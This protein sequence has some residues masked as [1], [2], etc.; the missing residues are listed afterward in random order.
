LRGCSSQ[1]VRPRVSWACQPPSL[2][3]A[4]KPKPVSQH[5]RTPGSREPAPGSLANSRQP[6]AGAGPGRAARPGRA[7]RRREGERERD[8]LRRLRRGGDRLR[9]YREELS[10]ERA[11][12]G[13][14]SAS[15]PGHMPPRPGRLSYQA[16]LY[17]GRSIPEAASTRARSSDPA[18]LLI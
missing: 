1:A 5:G 12:A 6:R 17:T 10:L 3:S 14:R 18:H 13:T 7:Q 4:R 2:L 15:A 11:R 16:E 9:L 8:R